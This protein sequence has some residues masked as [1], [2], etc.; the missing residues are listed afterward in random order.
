MEESKLRAHL[1]TLYCVTAAAILF[2]VLLAIALLFYREADAQNRE[3]FSTL[4]F[5]VSDQMSR[6]NA[7]S[8]P[9]LRELEQENRLLLSLRDNGE[10]LLYN[11]ID[12]ED[13]RR[14]LAEAERLAKDDGY[15]IA[16]LP[17][18]SARRVSPIYSFSEGGRR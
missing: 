10:R 16:M 8:H 14:L 5:A 17:L 2:V 4:L 1:V 7:V 18:T 6:E 13:K 11:S 9:H 15:D 12:G 3:A